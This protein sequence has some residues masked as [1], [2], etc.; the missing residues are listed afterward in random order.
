MPLRPGR[1]RGDTLSEAAG[2]LTSLESMTVI[3]WKIPLI[4]CL[5]VEEV[6]GQHPQRDKETAL[7][8]TWRIRL[9]CVRLFLSVCF[10]RWGACKEKS[11]EDGKRDGQTIQLTLEQRGGWGTDPLQGRKFWYNVQSA[12]HNVP[13]GSPASTSRDSTTVDSAALLY[14]LLKTSACQWTH[15]LP[16]RVVQGSPVLR[17]G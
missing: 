4:S 15:T 12:V 8:Q 6:P 11:R 17:N 14:L 3:K 13:Q 10:R 16:I 7:Y 2:L 9:Y 5:Q 1:P